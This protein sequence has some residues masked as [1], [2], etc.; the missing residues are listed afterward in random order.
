MSSWEYDLHV[1]AL[2]V[3]GGKTTRVI[4]RMVESQT[5]KKY[6]IADGV[7]EQDFKEHMLTHYSTQ[8]GVPGNV[9]F[10]L[11]LNAR[12]ISTALEEIARGVLVGCKI[13]IYL[14]IADQKVRLDLLEEI[15][16]SIP[17]TSIGELVVTQQI[18][19]NEERPFKKDW[20]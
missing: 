5:E 8:E 1:I 15:Y 9:N 3:G 10:F 13:G 11:L 14:D 17:S 7:T 12:G 18:A 19:Q 16:K 2:P 4:K 6:F 20:K